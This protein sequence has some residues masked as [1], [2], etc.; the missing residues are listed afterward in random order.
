MLLNL[1]NLPTCL[2]YVSLVILMLH[3]N[4][5]LSKI[6]VLA[7]FGRMALTNYLMQSFIQASFFYGW[8]LGNFGMGR[9]QQLGF[10]IVV[11]CLQVLFS[12]WWLAR[13]RYG[14]ME[15]IWRGITYWH[16]PELKNAKNVHGQVLNS[17]S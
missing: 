9:A 13:F 2:A 4:S 17:M 6:R 8:G 7:P 16:I 14:P 11:I 1:G 3:S 10:A 15:W 5:V 12:H